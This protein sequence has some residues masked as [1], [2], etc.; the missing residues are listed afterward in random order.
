M[1]VLRAYG[2]HFDVDTYMKK[3][4]LQPCLIYHRGEHK[5]KKTNPKKYKWPDSGI[6]V[7]VSNASF[8]NFRRQVKD[9]IKF[10][11]KN[12]SEIKKLTNF[13]GVEGVQLDFPVSHDQ[14][15]Y[16][17]EYFFPAELIVLA[18]ALSLGLGI[19]EY[20]ESN[21]KHT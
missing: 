16:I 17:Q 5:L 19:S 18:S 11:I 4:K 8:E 15:K 14:E 9:A 20:P 13:K 21:E 10:L 1:C 3:S 6:N 12:K 2:K 7:P